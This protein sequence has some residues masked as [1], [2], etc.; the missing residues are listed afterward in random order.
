MVLCGYDP[1]SDE[2]LIAD[3]LR[4]NP[5]YGTQYYRENVERVFNAICLG[6]ITYDAN[7]L[8][9]SKPGAGEAKP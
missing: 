1:K 9:L 2:V 5:G 4:D 3:P 6:V 7:T 8:V